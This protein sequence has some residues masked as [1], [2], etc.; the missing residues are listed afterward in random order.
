[1]ITLK[2]SF[3]YQN[4]LS[5]LLSSALSVLAYR[6]N[7][8]TTTQKHLRKKSYS[9]AT[10]EVIVVKKQVEHPYKIND[11][12]SFI[13]ILVNEIDYLTHAINKAKSYGDKSYDAMIA[14]N[15]KKRN[16]LRIYETMA[17]L[18][19][20]ESTIKGEADKFN[21][22]G[23]QVQYKY[24]IE[25]V[26]TID[27]DRNIIKGKISRLRHELDETS[28]AIDEMQLHSKVDYE[29]IFEIGESFEDIMESYAKKINS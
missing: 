24:D 18:K 27:F 1:M 25:Q 26:T 21:A 17:G 19:A 11:L 23:E 15:N 13:D 9:E 3:E 8:T 4:Y 22:D 28:D 14:M 12:V 20:S 16:I 2:K 6:D 10:D 7:I 5:E 29:P